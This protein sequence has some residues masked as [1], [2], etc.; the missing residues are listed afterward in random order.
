[1]EGA[2][3]FLV[4]QN[5]QDW[6]IGLTRWG[7]LRYS[8]LYPGVDLV[9]HSTRSGF[10]WEFQ[11]QENV[12][13]SHLQLQVLGADQLMQD[14]KEIKLSTGIGEITLPPLGINS[15]DLNKPD[16][17]SVSYGEESGLLSIYPLV[18]NPEPQ[19]LDVSENLVY[20]TFL[21]GAQLED[22]TDLD[23]DAYGNTYIVGTTSSPDFPVTPGAFDTTYVQTDAFV[24][25]INAA[26]ESL[27]YATYIGGDG[28]EK[29]AGVA[30]D[31]GIAYI[32]GESDSPNFPIAGAANDLD[33]F[34]VALNENGNGLI[35]SK[36]FGG[37]LEDRGY[38]L[39]IEAGSAYLTGITFSSDF[40]V[41]NSSKYTA[42]GDVFAVK[43][44]SNGESVYA[45]FIGGNKTDAGYGLDVRSGIAWITGETSTSNFGGTFGGVTDAFVVSLNAAGEKSSSRLF[46]GREDD[47]GYDIVLDSAGD[48]Y[49][50]GYTNSIA[51]PV[52]EGSWGGNYDAFLLKLNQSSTL[53]ATYLG[54]DDMDQGFG[55]ALDG[56]GGVVVTGFTQ[57][58]NFQV[59]ASAFQSAQA[60]AG[61]AFVTRFFL[62]GSDPG[63]RSYSTYLGGSSIERALALEMHDNIYANLVGETRSSDFPT[64][65]NGLYP[66]LNGIQDGFFSVMAVGPVPLI[67]I[68][69]STN[70]Y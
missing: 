21:G 11:V 6:K 44:N 33:A 60:G 43:L 54:G 41:T 12:D 65:A 26:G 32:V 13:V 2:V 3:S 5:P 30:V 22:A 49:V 53:Y 1:M 66:T 17:P 25:K 70:E 24:A 35:Y 39:D 40:P 48:I 58:D 57:S 47:R 31:G 15:L 38:A 9:V 68:Q 27:V 42:E 59:T 18:I 46:G 4:G 23:I 10:S 63:H 55:L 19:I 67:S 51:F 37:E 34:A 14:K 62:A 36:L 64:T 45:T 52:T 7:T 50:T 56:I 29:A 61:D 69:K 8:N 28:S 16:F 20:S